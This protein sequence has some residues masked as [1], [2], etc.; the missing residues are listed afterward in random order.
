[1]LCDNHIPVVGHIGLIPSHIS[2]S[3]WRAVGKAAAEAAAIWRQTHMLE[4]IGVFAA[5]LAVVPDRVARYL[6]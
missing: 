5:E 6:N 1:V 3:G 2:W 4:Q